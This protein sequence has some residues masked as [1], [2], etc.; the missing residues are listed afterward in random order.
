MA[1]KDLVKSIM[2]GEELE[3]E[4]LIRC[5]WYESR[6]KVDSKYGGFSAPI[7]DNNKQRYTERLEKILSLCYKEQ[8]SD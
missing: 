4:N 7:S 1:V 6:L 2:N 3:V 5:K 8:E